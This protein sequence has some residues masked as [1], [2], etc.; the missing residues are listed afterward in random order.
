M[1][2]MGFKN[3][4]NDPFVYLELASSAA[5]TAMGIESADNIFK[6]SVVDSAGATPSA[7]PQF[8]IDG[9]TNGNITFEPNGSGGLKSPATYGYAVG[10]TNQ[11]MVIDSTGLI[12]S[13][14]SAGGN[15][16][17][18]SVITVDT[19][20][21]AG[22]GYIC[23][24]AGTVTVT[25][26][27]TAAVGA[28]FG[29]TGMNNATGWKLAVSSGQTIHFGVATTTTTTGYLQS[30]ATYNV[31]QIVCNVAN[32]GFIVLSAQGNITVV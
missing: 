30:A 27:A 12:G 1:A 13:S 9:S 5:S 21:V 11:V 22:H 25:L 20:A 26:P 31:A 14:A 28:L 17:I 32:T 16:L 8:Q 3:I 15:G 19:A 2:K 4:S 18:W 23:N 7:V 29:V 24:G 10:G 6:I